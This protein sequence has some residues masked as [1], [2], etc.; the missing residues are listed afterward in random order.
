MVNVHQEFKERPELV[1]KMYDN[2]IPLLANQLSELAEDELENE[3]A[4]M[5]Y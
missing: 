1:R 5:D 3:D 4:V 2:V